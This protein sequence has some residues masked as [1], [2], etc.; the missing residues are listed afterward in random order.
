MIFSLKNVMTSMIL[1][2]LRKNGTKLKKKF[3]EEHIK[4]SLRP[5]GSGTDEIFKPTFVF[6]DQLQFLTFICEGDGTLDS[7]ERPPNPYP[8]KKSMLQMQEDRENRKLELFSQAV[9]CHKRGTNKAKQQ[10]YG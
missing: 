10:K 7:I 1:H 6:Y 2:R 3:R 8:R 9:K 5:S 4:A